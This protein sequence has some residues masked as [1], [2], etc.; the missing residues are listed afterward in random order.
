MEEIKSMVRALCLLTP[1]FL[2]LELLLPKGETR[3]YA[4]CVFGLIEMLVLLRPALK[5]LTAFA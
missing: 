5:L 3:G 4:R 2:L 1:L